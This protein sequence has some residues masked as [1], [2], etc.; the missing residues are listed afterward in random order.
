MMTPEKMVEMFTYEITSQLPIE[1]IAERV[2]TDCEQSKFALLK[3]YVYHDIVKSKGFPI[4]RKVFIYEICQAETAAKMLT[5][6]PH[7]SIFMPC[8]LVLYEKDGETIVSTM[9]MEAVLDL[10]RSD[11]GLYEGA[12]TLFEV[13]K[14]L[15][16]NISK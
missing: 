7:F 12:T 13:L 4:N 6:F 15:M 1:K 8:K 11:S 3:N 14:N 10:V 16:D 2:P 5:G 9:N